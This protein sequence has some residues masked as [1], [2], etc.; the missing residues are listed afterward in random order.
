[1]LISGVALKQ[2]YKN[3]L[4]VERYIITIES[5]GVAIK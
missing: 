5:C 2:N 1:M 4:R 3:T